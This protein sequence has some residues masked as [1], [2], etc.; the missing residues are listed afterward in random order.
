M[1]DDQPLVPVFMP[2][3]APLMIE[4]EEIKGAPLT[5]AEVLRIR[6]HALCVMTPLDVARAMV[7]SR[8]YEDLDPENCW[9]EWQ[10][11]RREL[12]RA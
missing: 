7:E 2:A 4:A 10:A 12:G 1:A 9:A 5:E 3:L 11:L 6:D 8:G